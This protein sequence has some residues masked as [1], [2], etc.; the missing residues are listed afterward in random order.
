MKAVLGSGSST[1]ASSNGFYV[2]TSP[3]IFNKRIMFYMDVRQGEFFPATFQGSNDTIKAVWLCEDDQ[4]QIEVS[5][6]SSASGE[7]EKGT[8]YIW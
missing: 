5:L 6:Q 7:V 3:P 4:S 2:D 8:G 1:W